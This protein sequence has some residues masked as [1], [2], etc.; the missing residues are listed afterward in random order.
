MC[1]AA[2]TLLVSNFYDNEPERGLRLGV[3]GM[4][5]GL[6]IESALE[7]AVARTEAAAAPPKLAAAVRHAVFPGGARVR[8]QLCLA[9]A[10]ACGG[11]DPVVV[12]GAAAAIE[13]LH[14][15]SLVHDDLPCFDDAA[16]RRG[17]PSVHVAFGEPLAVL[18]GDALIVMAF[19]TLAHACAGAPD[20]LAPLL[21][22]LA[23]GVG[24]P[25]GIVAGQAW[26][27]EPNPCVEA[28]HRAKTGALFVATVMC[29]A[30]AARADPL[31]WRRLGETLGA[32][33]QVAD[34]L[35]D[36]LSGETQLGKPA[37]RDI[38][39]KRPS[40]AASLGLKTAYAHMEALVSDAVGS[41]PPCRGGRRL[42][43]LV[44]TC[45]TRLAPEQL[46]RDAA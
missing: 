16:T 20:L 2:A 5:T 21:T 18:A 26:E 37:G 25:S 19:D 42:K 34:D 38:A 24:P 11:G 8:P 6:R 28:Y 4:T 14:C 43:D 23:R 32:A 13:L 46:V 27:S 41:I 29:G 7:A 1:L 36:A 30:A 39:L 31:P 9:V 12:D 15:A 35:A 45:A 22:T 3:D 40:Q 10:E 33:Y 17:R 44:R